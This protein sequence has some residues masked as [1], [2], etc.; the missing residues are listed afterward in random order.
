MHQTAV[1]LCGVALA[2]FVLQRAAEMFVSWYSGVDPQPPPGALLRSGVEILFATTAAITAIATL[3][4][5]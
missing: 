5:A 1:Y 3:P 4:A 2:W